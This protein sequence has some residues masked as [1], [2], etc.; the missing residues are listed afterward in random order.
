M[1]D[2]ADHARFEEAKTELQLLLG[3]DLLADC[4]LLVFCNKIDMPGAAS[5]G[6]MVKRLELDRV[7]GRRQW[8]VQTAC[9]TSGEGLYEGLEWLAKALKSH[10]P[11]RGGATFAP[12]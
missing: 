9:A 4:I 2:A 11:S 8:Y 5:A 12:H 3:E 10:K 1:V 7:A 6:E